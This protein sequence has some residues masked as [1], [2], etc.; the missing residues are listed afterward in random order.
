M[1]HRGDAVGRARG[2][3]DQTVVLGVDPVVVDPENDVQVDVVGRCGDHHAAR[4]GLQVSACLLPP[5]QGAG[6]FHH[7]VHL[8]RR[9]RQ[10]LRILL[11]GEGDAIV[12]DHEMPLAAADLLVEPSV[13]RVVLQ[14][15]GQV[16]EVGEIV[17]RH[18]LEPLAFVHLLEHATA[19]PSESVDG[20]TGGAHGAPSFRDRG[21]SSSTAPSRGDRE[22]SS[23]TMLSHAP[24]RPPADVRKRSGVDAGARGG[25]HPEGPVVSAPAA[26]GWSPGSPRPRPGRNRRRRPAGRRWDRFRPNR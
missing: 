17:D 11:G 24:P 13:H 4:A 3:R 18:D 22:R 6:G 15:V 21:N 25:G 20:H 5:A 26:P 2:G 1:E 8:A 23:S 7:H 19:D 12:V 10:G 14:E 9:P 16:V